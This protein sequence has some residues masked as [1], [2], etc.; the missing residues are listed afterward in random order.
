MSDR[1]RLILAFATVYLVW[2]STYLGIRFA[3]ETLPPFLMAGSRFLIAGSIL[4]FVCLFKREARPTRTQVRNAVIVGML[5]LPFGNGCVTW[6]ETQLASGLA[7]LLVAVEPA[8]VVL[9]EWRMGMRNRLGFATV[10]GLLLGI[11][12][13]VLLIAEPGAVHSIPILPV[14]IVIFA[15]IVWAYGSLWGRG[16]EMPASPMQANSIQMLVGGAAMFLFGLGRGEAHTLA[17]AHVSVTSLAAF[18]YLVVFG[19]LGAFTA[20]TYLMRNAPPTLTA[21]YSYVNPAVAVLLGSAFGEPFGMRE[22]VAMALV[23]VGVIVL[24]RSESDKQGE[25]DRKSLR[26]TR[27]K[28]RLFHRNREKVGA[29][30]QQ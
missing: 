8:W 7:A 10:A 26:F 12:G 22:A 17:S 18:A 2:G 11:A 16:V 14:G 29:K 5:L 20:Y 4:T 28:D 23:L 6:A 19:S 21:T 25:Q 1:G 30:S 27:R 13:V 9:L 3:I 15:T 24:S